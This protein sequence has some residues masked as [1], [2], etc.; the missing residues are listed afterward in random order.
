MLLG[1]IMEQL[2]PNWA[3]IVAGIGKLHEK[4]QPHLH[5][6]IVLALR[7]PLSAKGVK[8][9]FAIGDP[10]L[11]ADELVGAVDKEYEL[12]VVPHWTDKALEHNPIFLRYK[13]KIIRVSDDPLKV[14]REIGQCKKIV[15]SSLHGIIVADAFNIPRR[16]EIAPRMLTHSHQEGGIFKWRDYAASVGVPFKIGLTQEADRNKVMERQHELYDALQE[17]IHYGKTDSKT[18]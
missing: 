15:S 5:N 14:I 3:G 7:G 9:D 1:S 2:P 10:A 18:D 13:P 6:A 8:G 17:V 16:T 12:G 11:L 4:T